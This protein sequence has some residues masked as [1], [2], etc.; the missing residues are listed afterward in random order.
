[1]GERWAWWIALPVTF[2]ELRRM[3][4]REGLIQ[5]GKRADV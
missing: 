2:V 5:G 3:L 4:Q 1:V